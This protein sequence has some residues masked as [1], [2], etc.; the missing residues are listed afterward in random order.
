[1]DEQHGF[2]EATSSPDAPSPSAD[3][4]DAA[5]TTAGFTERGR[6]LTLLALAI[7][8]IIEGALALLT[9]FAGAG[10]R[11]VLTAGRFALITGMAY[12]TYQ[13][14][15]VPRWL[16]VVLAGFAAVVGGP[17]GLHLAI[18]AGSPGQAVLVAVSMTGYA[19]AAWLLAGS[20]AVRAYLRY[21]RRALDHDRLR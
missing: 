2:E 11:L 8:V 3:G 15:A 16:L 10:D 9:V 12:M 14:F 5:S 18:T 4:P 13:G 7:V 1:M 17:H 6:D 19:T 20:P 21:R